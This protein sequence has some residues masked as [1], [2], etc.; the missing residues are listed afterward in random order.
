MQYIIVAFFILALYS[1][2]STTTTHDNVIRDEAIST[3]KG[4]RLQIKQGEGIDLRFPFANSEP[5]DEGTV[6]HIESHYN[7]QNIGFDLVLHREGS[8]KL[9]LKTTGAESDQFLQVL[10]GLYA[11]EADTSLKFT[12]RIY[13]DC[14]P[15]GDYMERMVKNNHEKPVRVMEKKL[16]FQGR[17]KD[18]YAEFYLRVNEKEQWIELKETDSSY[19]PAF[20]KLLTQ[21]ANRKRR[22]IKNARPR[23][24]GPGK[25]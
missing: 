17:K 2:S 12:E 3:L 21:K 20:I 19:R 10:Q 14:L 11:Q 15:M 16:F 5:T 1:C 4:K 22:T 25:V 6:Y 9:S 18:E 13:A 24:L 7:G 23:E 8:L